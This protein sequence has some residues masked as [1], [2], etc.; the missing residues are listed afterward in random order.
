MGWHIGAHTVSHP[1]LS[2]L[3][4]EDM[5]G[6]VIREEL[7]RCNRVIEENMG[8]VPEDFAFTGTSWSSAAEV[9]VK[10]RYRFGRLWV[11][12]SEYEADGKTNTLRG[13]GRFGRTV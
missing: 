1:N 11:I 5:D 13:T 6:E 9:E 8:F 3:A 10:K 7:D 12:G 2:N 4:A